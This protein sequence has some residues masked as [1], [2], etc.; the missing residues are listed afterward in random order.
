[1]KD[2]TAYSLSK[3]LLALVLAMFM[4]FGN[5]EFAGLADFAMAENGQS[6]VQVVE[7]VENAAP[8]SSTDT[9]SPSPSSQSSGTSSADAGAGSAV[10]TGETTT[11]NETGETPAQDETAEEGTEP[12]EQEPEQEN[13][14]EAEPTATPKPAEEP[15]DEPSHIYYFFVLGKQI[16]SYTTII[17]NQQMMY[18][19]E[20]EE[21][22]RE[23][24]EL[25][26]WGTEEIGGP[27]FEQWG[28]PIT[29]QN[30]Q[31]I[32][33]YAKYKK[34][35]SSETEN[36]TEAGLTEE[37]GDE[38][39]EEEESLEEEL[40]E[41][42]AGFSG[43]RRIVAPNDP[44]IPYH[45]YKFIVDGAEKSKQIIAN[46]ES[47]VEPAKPEKTGFIF[48]GWFTQ[49]NGGTQFTTFASPITVA[50]T[51]DISLYAQF[52]QKY[53]VFFVDHKNKV[54]R[55]EEGVAGTVVNTSVADNDVALLSTQKLD[56]WYANSSLSGNKL[57][58]VTLN[59]P[60]TTVYAKVVNGFW[61]SYESNGGN[62][63]DPSF[64]LAGQNT[65]APTAPTKQGY[66]FA[67]WFNEAALTSQ[68]NFGAPITANK[69]VYAK[70]TPANTNYEIVYWI[71]DPDVHTNY[72]FLKAVSA[73]GTTGT[74][75]SLS[76][77]QI[78]KDPHI[79][80]TTLRR[81]S[82][83]ARHDQNV[84]IAAD[85][86][87]KVNVYFDRNTYSYVFNINDNAVTL[88]I[89]GTTYTNSGPRY[90]INAKFDEDI[91]SRWPTDNNI[92][93]KKLSRWNP[94]QISSG[95]VTKR[96][97]VTPDMI[98]SSGTTIDLNGNYGQGT[99]SRVYYMAESFQALGGSKP[100]SYT[101]N[102]KRYDSVPEYQQDVY[103]SLTAK[104][105]PGMSKLGSNASKIDEVING[106]PHQFFFYTRNEFKLTRNNKG[107]LTEVNVKYGAD[108]SGY[109]TAPTRPGSVPANFIFDGWYTSPTFAPAS[110]F[111]FTG[112]TMPP[113]NMI[114]YAYWKAPELNVI[115]HKGAEG[116]THTN[117]TFTIP[118]N[119]S[120]PAPKFTEAENALGLASGYQFGG[121]YRKQGN[122]KV[123]FN[124]GTVL[125]N[126]VE[127]WPIVNNTA[128]FTLTY[129]AGDG[130]GTV[131]DSAKYAENSFASILSGAS[132]TPP[133]GKKFMHWV[134]TT[135]ANAQVLPGDRIIV[136]G[137]ETLRAFYAPKEVTTSLDYVLNHNG[138]TASFTVNNIPNNSVHNVLTVAATGL[139]AP[140][141]YT[142]L[143]WNTAV[144]GGGTWYNPAST[145]RVNANNP[146]SNKLYGQWAKPV[147]VTTTG[148]SF[149]YDGTQKVPTV[150][151]SE[152]PAGYAA[153]GLSGTRPT[154]W[155]NGPRAAT[156]DTVTIKNAAGVD[157]TDRMQITKVPGTIEIT[158]R[159]VTLTSESAQKIFDGTALTNNN[160]AIS[161]SGFVS[162]QG[163]TT[164]VT[165]TQTAVG[166]S[167]NT[168]R[169]TFNP[170][171]TDTN[172]EITQVLGKLKV[173][174]QTAGMVVTIEG[175]TLV[176]KYNG[177]QRSVNGY[178]V[179]SIRFNGQPT[180]LY[181]ENDL[182]LK[183]NVQASAT[184]KDVGNYPMRLTAESFEN[185]NPNYSNVQFVVTD[186]KL[187][188][189]KRDITLTSGTSTRVYNGQALTNHTVTPS[190]DGWAPGEGANY[191][192]TGTQTD[193][194]SSKNRFTYNLNPNTKDSNYNIST[195][196]GD[197]TVTKL[198]SGIV[199]RIQ[200]KTD[201]KVYNAQ[202]QTV[203]GYTVTGITL[204]GVATTLYTENHFALKANA[205]AKATGKNVNTYPMGLNANS[206]EN[207]NTNFDNVTFQVTDGGLTITKRN[208]ILTSGTAT[209]VYDGNPLVKHEVVP[210]GEGF[211]GT[212]GADYAYPTSITNFGSIDND[213]TVTLKNGALDGNYN[214]TKVKGTLSI[215]KLTGITVS[216]K[217]KTKET[218]FDG[219]EH[220]AEGY[221]VTMSNPLYPASAITFNGTARATR[222][223]FGQSNMNLLPTQFSNN[224][225]NFDNVTFN[226]TDGYVKINP[227]GSVTVTVKG[228]KGTFTYDGSAKTVSNYDI[229][230]SDPDYNI[231]ANVNFSGNAN[232]SR[233]DAGTSP[234][235]LAVSQF[236]NTNSNYNNVVFVVEDGSITIE[237]LANLQVNIIG[238][239]GSFQYNGQPHSVNNYTANSANAFFV[240]A[241]DIVFSGQALAT[242][243]EV[244]TTPM[245][246]KKVQFANSNTNFKD[247]NF[248][249]T[250]GSVTV[251]PNTNLVVTIDGKQESK[252]YNGTTQSTIGFTVSAIKLGGQDTTL[253]T[254]AQVRLASGM[255]AKAEGKNAGDYAMNL[256][257]A[258]FTHNNSNFDNITYV[259]ND[260]KLTVTK[261]NVILTSLDA[262]RPYN[263]LA[264]TKEEVKVTGD[265][266]APG[267]GASYVFSG[268]QTQVGNSPN[269]FTYNLN[270]NTLPI[271]YDIQTVPGR[272][273]VTP[274]RKPVITIKGEKKTLTYD[275][276][277]HSI[278][279]YT[280]TSNNP[281]FN[282]TTDLTYTGPAS[283]SLTNAGTIAMGL[284]PSH[285]A[286]SNPNFADVDF[287]IIDGGIT[288]NKR[289]ITLTSA[290][291]DKIF[292]GTALTNNTVAV[293]G[294]GYAAGE[295]FTYN[296][297]G[298]QTDVGTSNNAFTISDNTARQANYDVTI[299]LGKLTVKGAE[300]TVNIV[301]NNATHVYDGTE[302]SVNSFVAT[303]VGPSTYNVASDFVFSGTDVAKRTNA[304]KTMMGLKAGQFRNTNRNF[305]KVTFVVTDGF[306]EITPLQN[307]T[308]DII[309]NT[310]LATYDG[311]PKTVSGYS[312]S[313][314]SPLMTAR[315]FRYT[316]KA[317]VSRTAAGISPM[318]LDATKFVVTNPNFSNVTFNIVQDGK[319]EV[320]QPSVV[321]TIKGN[322]KRVMYNSLEHSVDGF[323]YTVNHPLYK[324]SDFGTTRPL[325]V[326]GTNVNTYHM[327]LTAGDFINNNPNF[328]V[329]FHVD[330]DGE[331]D[332]YPATI[333][334]K[335]RGNSDTVDYDGK[336]HTVRGYT[337]ISNN[338]AFKVPDNIVFSGTDSVTRT[339]AGIS[340]MGLSLT[341]FN[342]NLPI[343]GNIASIDFEVE[344]GYINI[345]KAP[346]KIRVR[347][348]QR[349][350]AF[351]G[352][353]K[354]SKGYEYWVLSGDIYDAEANLVYLGKAEAARREQG[355]T[356]MNLKKDLFVNM[357]PL[358][359]VEVIVEDGWV[360]ITKPQGQLTYINMVGTMNLS[361]GLQERNESGSLESRVGENW[362][363]PFTKL[364]S[365]LSAN[366]NSDNKN[367]ESD[368]T[369]I[370]VAALTNF[371][372]AGNPTADNVAKDDF[373]QLLANA[374]IDLVT[375]PSANLNLVDPSVYQETVNLLDD[376][377][378]AN[379]AYESVARIQV[380]SH[381]KMANFAVRSN[382][383][384]EEIAQRVASLREDGDN[385]IV[386]EVHWDEDALAEEVPEQYRSDANVKRHIR[387]RKKAMAEKLIDAGT[388]VVLGYNTRDVE[389]METYKNGL[390]FY[391][392]GDL[393]NGGHR[394]PDSEGN[395][396][397][398]IVQLEVLNYEDKKTEV[399]GYRIVPIS[400]SSSKDHNDYQ[401]YAYEKGSEGYWRVR[402]KLNGTWGN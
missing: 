220:V 286:S 94:V 368:V 183:P 12:V 188:I 197:L 360:E 227:K 225:P 388:N 119:T 133:A 195:V 280:A 124:K 21:T 2:Y 287:V 164:I 291:Q 237:P 52:E 17:K 78:N 202:N 245:N 216:I 221:D 252:L 51:Q 64:F 253:F 210:S 324:R 102:G 135:G 13:P 91:A 363:Y 180:S 335:I 356:Y 65:A 336:P 239:T 259:I 5:M 307:I 366:K 66:S 340:Y 95:W 382:D 44:S 121:W 303:V 387:L 380:G 297:T 69:I 145:L 355:T 275:G 304:G 85:G 296:F 68:Y 86:S 4:L 37:E 305:S 276:Q 48:K 293:S 43:F 22:Y 152:L 367:G 45:N 83:Y 267:E 212:E 250:D 26:G 109:S 159:K 353:V 23:G 77:A 73:T 351:D 327:N 211:A 281:L 15:S 171:T 226:V 389:E 326:S 36:G 156:A 306:V 161:G 381:F 282:P 400:L 348:I 374:G 163:V 207:K 265:K 235:G 134:H 146:G 49:A 142:F 289:K 18:M 90:T 114:L 129:Q 100:D 70:W 106:I 116:T 140:S 96:N 300:V 118:Y 240:P 372:T 30:S 89:G 33:L 62:A 189:N 238:N 254:A 98:P 34:T 185:I 63:V 80:D 162:G 175:N 24:Y 147:T 182:R 179:K 39:T 271:N 398:L 393:L 97:K 1:M 58:S 242:R 72:Q 192:Y 378:I 194:G 269:N 173:T 302:R 331:L 309:G 394:E 110:K 371:F 317:S 28:V 123:S 292:D 27:L 241:R 25:I 377:R 150:S 138:S 312:S 208:L 283:V 268:T 20:G 218:T 153:V 214:I 232:V 87:T 299:K 41:D 362:M 205:Q 399:P 278:T 157:V 364:S 328:N 395:W 277:A 204:N 349:S 88:Q 369:H 228:N 392:L 217:G 170:G 255:Q 151:F 261:R 172:Y 126:D 256:S 141:G 301:G 308:V 384:S 54:V 322:T 67:G 386:V 154:N 262:E 338:A 365:I 370:T 10:T 127:L 263:G 313:T 108:I 341:D 32:N 345:K 354:V 31:D 361:T 136:R 200:G 402:K 165:G 359:E 215:S 144:N 311:T 82:E 75:V 344:D 8:A 251:T 40:E 29:V 260:G 105:L 325:K 71:Q 112:K 103:T 130:T 59:S 137:H 143:G 104:D 38:T 199:V 3:R 206:F 285:F 115:L 334:V 139:N 191:S 229:T 337:A 61:I 187:S 243:T 249:I 167:D 230:A 273:E 14:T 272:L 290:T 295:V 314:S 279:S 55:T 84:V 131:T 35:E 396:D 257:P 223:V 196:E 357:D 247:V 233:T 76:T 383:F 401:P 56:G 294:E 113:N 288:I 158:K 330:S 333:K 270:S 213:F 352:T 379:N 7:S 321:V 178:T 74:T 50:A 390:I 186:G 79:A 323:T 122:T 6:D 128:E 42:E 385:L 111:N 319:V 347:G 375:L 391:G 176:D 101:L 60:S 224:N 209:K 222:T 19:P 244:G 120:I 318:N 320:T 169:Y 166:E 46:G 201:S 168:F 92:V 234:M 376:S 198:D 258:H 310:L 193:V 190:V 148:G 332:I 246:L 11:P 298:T 99:Y 117:L 248:V 219:N 266:F 203:E 181:T 174:A 149:E 346:V 155:T 397:A 231:A 274:P 373:M 316:G 339:F 342:H 236:S 53:Y 177:T 343:G 358:F 160:V 47:L 350:F 284:L 264:L 9:A 329:V 16:E 184:G 81:F 93:G 57:T 315:D 107:A 125:T 132:L